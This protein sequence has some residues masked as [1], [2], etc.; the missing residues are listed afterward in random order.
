MIGCMATGYRIDDPGRPFRV[1][2]ATAAPLAK[3]KPRARAAGRAAR[4]ARRRGRRR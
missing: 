1:R 4:V 3:V 2:R